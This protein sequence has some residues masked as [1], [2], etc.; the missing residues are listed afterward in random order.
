MPWSEEIYNIVNS[1]SELGWL[2]KRIKLCLDLFKKE[3]AGIS[4]FTQSFIYAIQKELDE[5]FKLISFF[6]KMN[7]SKKGGKKIN[8]KNLYLWT[9]EPKEKLKWLAICCE[10]VFNL[11]GAAIFSQ[12]YSL[13]NLL[14]YNTYLDNILNEVSKPFLTFVINWIKYGNLEDPYK[15][16]FVEILDGIHNDDIWNLKYQ[17]IAKNVPNF[18]KREKTIKI[19]EVGKGLHFMRNYCKEKFNLANLNII[20]ENKIKDKNISEFESL[21]ECYEFINYIFDNL[22]N[23]KILDISLI[24]LLN[25]NIDI[26][27]ELLNEEILKTI[28]NKFKFNSNLESINKYLLLGQGDMIQTLIESLFDELDKPATNI[29]KHN[30]ESNLTTAIK[31]SNSDITD[32]ENIKKLNVI[33]LNSSQ[34]DIGWDIFC[35]EYNVELPLNIIFTNKLLKDYQ[36]LFLFF[37]KIKRIEFGQINYIWKKIKNLNYN[38]IKIKNNSFI[39]NLIHT[40]IIFN[41]ETVHFMTNLHNYFSL[42]VLETQ[43]KKL[44]L[45]LS[46]IKKLDDLINIHKL[47]VENIKKQCLL[48][49]DN[50]NIIIKISEIF[51]IILQYKKVFE[52]LYSFAFEINYENN[53]NFKRIKN[54][55]E[56]L[57]QMNTLYSQYKLKIIEFIKIIDLIGKN[58]IKYLAMKLDYNYYYTNIEKEKKDE[59]D[60]KIIKDINNEKIRQKILSDDDYNQSENSKNNYDDNNNLIDNNKFKN[61][62]QDNIQN[63]KNNENEMEEEDEKINNEEDEEEIK[64]EEYNNDKH[65]NNLYR[66]ND[67]LN[68]ENDGINDI[69][70]NQFKNMKDNNNN[71]IYKKYNIIDNTYNNNFIINN[72]NKNNVYNNKEKNLDINANEDEIQNGAKTF[73]YENNDLNQ[74]ELDNENEEEENNLDNIDDEEDKIVTN[75]IPKIYG[76][77]TKGKQQ[78]DLD[79]KK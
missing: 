7:N 34:G 54:I 70:I 61:E 78:N 37:W 21:N 44:K 76:L 6:K 60:L 4:Q 17:L 52:V 50:R 31:A 15:E 11:K 43:Y 67:E 16:F 77:S 29:L 14:G 75:I 12:I 53:I 35:L 45:D 22:N 68:L 73:Q 13:K 38:S 66:K 25:K 42:E 27:Y 20:L 33:L 3:K 48:D 36:K 79:E 72:G 8:L 2:Y 30:L 23:E 56:Y 9:L 24:D 40:S 1:L 71:F 47:F 49:D 74:K 59:N 69:N 32:S 19:F 58:N 39:K 64:G 26:I 51:D 55:E 62:N 41:Q 65:K 57:K 10:T 63:N 5:Y 28:Y 18:M 46:K